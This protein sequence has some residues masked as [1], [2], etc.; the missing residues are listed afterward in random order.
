MTSLLSKP[1]V[2]FRVGTVR[3][4]IWRANDTPPDQARITIV[5]ARDGNPETATLRDDE[6]PMAMLALKKAHNYLRRHQ[7]RP[8]ETADFT[9]ADVLLPERIP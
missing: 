7:H 8:P 6:I 9:S 3:A 4:A 2:E 5:T 1:E